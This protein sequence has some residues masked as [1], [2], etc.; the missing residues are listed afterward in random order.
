MPFFTD[1]LTNFFDKH[2]YKEMSQAQVEGLLDTLIFAMIADGHVTAGE[3]T[4]LARAAEVLPW[5]GS[6]TI[7]S[8]IQQTETR[9]RNAS[10]PSDFLRDAASAL[11]EEWMQDDAYY[12]AARV[13]GAD[14]KVV[15]AETE[16]LHALT[17]ALGLTGERLRLITSRLINEDHV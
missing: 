14:D 10:H 17:T 11:D 4:E 9:L 2:K 8:Y 16:Y 12:L 7:D 5:E 13:A 1:F 15:A 6:G 3:R